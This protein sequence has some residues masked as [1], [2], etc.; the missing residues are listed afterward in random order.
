MGTMP[1]GWDQWESSSSINLF[2]GQI[3]WKVWGSNPLS[4]HSCCSPTQEQHSQTFVYTDTNRNPSIDSLLGTNNL[5]DLGLM[6]NHLLKIYIN[7]DANLGTNI[8]KEIIVK[9]HTQGTKV[10]MYKKVKWGDYKILWDLFVTP[11]SLPAKVYSSSIGILLKENN[12]FYLH[13]IVCI[14]LLMTLLESLLE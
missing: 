1:S 3:V 4:H 6:K 13:I 5:N 9:N 14:S 2:C 12:L 10:M 11:S 7:P 8:K